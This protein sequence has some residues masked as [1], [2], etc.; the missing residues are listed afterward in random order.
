MAAAADRLEKEEKG[1]LFALAPDL[2]EEEEK[3]GAIRHLP[4]KSLLLHLLPSL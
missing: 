4:G 2:E 3:E 1:S